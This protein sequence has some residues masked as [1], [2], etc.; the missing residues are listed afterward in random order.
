MLTLILTL[1]LLQQAPPK[2]DPWAKVEQLIDEGKLEAASAEAEKKLSAARSANDEG[3][4][5]RALVRLTQIRT[6]LGGYET[7]V[8]RLKAEAWPKG[9]LNRA[10]VE[11]YYANAVATYAL[12]YSW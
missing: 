5:A 2:T 8:K 10:A 6:G 1:S 7:A 11:L 12:M 3:E 9:A 4:M